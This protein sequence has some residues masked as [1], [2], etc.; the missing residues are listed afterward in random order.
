MP[1]PKSKTKIAI[2]MPVFQSFS[3]VVAFD[4]MRMMYSFG[5]RYPEYD[6]YLLP[7]MKSEQ[8]RARNSIVESA[9]KIG[10]KYLLFLDDDHVFGWKET[11]EHSQY[12]FLQKL[13]DH[14]KDIIGC[15]YFHRSGEYKP[16]LMKE[17]GDGKY[18]FLNDSEIKH[19]L[20]EV[21]V[22]GGGVMLIDL[23]I[24]DKILPPYFEPEQQ[25][26]GESLGTDVQLCKKARAAGFGVWC[27]TSI[28]VGHIKQDYDV[29]TPHNRNSFIGE[30]SMKGNIG[31]DWVVDNWMKG[32]RDA[33]RE[34]TGMTDEEIVKSAWLY[35]E[36]HMV[37]FEDYENK[38]EYYAKL[39]VEQLCRQMVYHSVSKVAW[40]GLVLLKHFT[41][42]VKT[43]G[44]DYGCGSAPVGF[45]VLKYGHKVDFV[46]IDGS[47]AYEFLKWR[48]KNSDRK[49][50]AG[51]KLAGPYDFALFLDS[52]EHFKDWEPILDNVIGRLKERGVLFT[53]FFDNRDFLNREH[54]NMDHKAVMDFLL[55]RRMFPKTYSIWIKDD[56]YMGGAMNVNNEKKLKEKAK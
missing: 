31:D 51:F 48:V 18:T 3:P 39:G 25:T 56:N 8:F 43:C 15:L 19:G 52:I 38:D 40:D 49:D 14:K 45:E 11:L 53:N 22:Q 37:N 36:K 42:G 1:K 20:Q 55:S 13:I 5:R 7:K 23:K 2:G 47:Y 34:Y 44:V 9:L 21:E 6:F 41:G 30:N 54:I 27:D 28:T 10:A 26:D 4:Y 33:V 29:I 17:I 35:D 12:D 24:F 50:N 16:V 46:D 32:Y